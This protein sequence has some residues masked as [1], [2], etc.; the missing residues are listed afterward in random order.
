MTVQITNWSYADIQTYMRVAIGIPSLNAFKPP[1][2]IK[3][4]SDT[5]P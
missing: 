2:R 3:A 1:T 5:S 4:E